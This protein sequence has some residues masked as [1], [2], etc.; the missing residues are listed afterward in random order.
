MEIKRAIR[1]A[2]PQ[3]ISISGVSGSGKSYSALLFAAGLAG[4]NG[5]VGLIDT[6]NGRGCTYSDSPGIMAALPQGYDVIE[7]GPPFSPRRYIEAI[8][9]FESAGYKVVVIDSGSHEWEGDGSASEMAEEDKKRWNRAKAEHKKFV[10]RL[11]TSNMHIIVCLRAR[12]KSKI[13]PKTSTSKEEV[14]SLGIQPIAEKSFVFEMLLS[15]MIEEKTHLASALKCPEPLAHL[16]PAP[17]LLTKLDGDRLRE[18]NETGK[19]PDEMERVRQRQQR[20]MVDT[21]DAFRDTLGDEFGA[22]LGRF[23]LAGA[24]EITDRELGKKVWR[25][26]DAA[27][28]ARGVAAIDNIEPMLDEL[29]EITPETPADASV[30]LKTV[31]GAVR[32]TVNSDC[33]AWSKT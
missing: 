25:A 15:F 1:H 9:A 31:D 4:P 28:K 19:S 29:P 10:Q 23:K 13:V 8:N 14:I 11:L 33:T 5:K 26:M 24:R 22:I 30:W 3:V 17:R 7:M 12:E 2:I 27:A 20:E 32:Y 16:F 18:W 6:E 21:I